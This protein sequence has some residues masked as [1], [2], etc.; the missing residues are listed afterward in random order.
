M[1]LD[2]K[3]KQKNKRRRNT[4]AHSAYGT[5][6][7]HRVHKWSTRSA[8]E[9]SVLILLVLITTQ[10]QVQ[11]FTSNKP[12]KTW[13]LLAPTYINFS[14]KPI[15]NAWCSITCSQEAYIS[16]LFGDRNL[17]LLCWIPWH[18]MILFDQNPI[19][20]LILTGFFLIFF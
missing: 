2:R 7:R 3:P 6:K 4:K 10:T 11:V 19:F 18:V 9:L 15:K 5:C 8:H 13:Q 12:K 20:R 1:G 16:M 14:H 17:G